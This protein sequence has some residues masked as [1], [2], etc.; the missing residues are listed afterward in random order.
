MCGI[1]GV[2]A[3]ASSRDQLERNAIAMADSLAYRG[4]DDHGIWS[5]AEAGLALTHRRLSIVD[6]SPAGHQPMVSADGRFI[7]TY[8]GEIYNFQDLRPD[9][10]ARGTK[11]RGH[12]DTE[13]MLEAFAVYGVEATVKRLIGMFTIGVWDRRE[14]TLTLVRDR[15]GIKPLYWANFSGLFLF[16]S[17]LK[18]LRAHPGWTP[19][20]NRSAVAA[21]MRH[22]YIPAPHTIYEGVHKLEPGTILTLPWNGEPKIERFWDARAIAHAGLADPLLADDSELTDRLEALLR[23]AVSRRMVADVPVGAFLSGGIDSSTVAALMKAANAGP[24]RTYTIGF[25]LPGFD[26]AVH[27]AAVARHLGTDHTELT[28][29]AKDALNVIPQLPNMYDEPFAD[30]SQIP[31][32][33]VSAMTRRHVT[34]AL[35]G[36]GGDELFAGYNRYQLTTRLWRSFAL[37]P[38][39][40]RRALA[41]MLTAVSADRW[42]QMLSIAPAGMRPPQIGD[43]LHKFAAVLCAEGD[44]DLY[45]RLVTHWDPWRVV[46]GAAE[47]KGVLWDSKIERDFPDLLERMQ[48]LDLVTYLPDDIL[49]KVDR[50]SMAVALE[51]RVPLID[52]RVVEFA[53]R[54]PRAVKIRGGVSKWLLR[55]VLYRHVPK[56]LVERPKM[57][58]G[59][60]LG[61]WLRGP[62]RGWADDLLAESRLRQAGLLDAAR[63]RQIWDAHLNGRRNH[64][65]MLW[66]VLML[67]AWRDRWA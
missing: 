54:L 5:D 8:N 58:F 9:L 33:L 50:A 4:P 64:E 53:W 67:E 27:S 36:D 61:D 60:P 25:E 16:G 42:T 56:A 19:R 39:P 45:R 21:F 29:T 51:A 11:F 57:G 49:T 17:E 40:M 18:A 26:E 46:P 59:I 37:L 55:Q 12:S 24:V 3:S 41:G 22:N 31:T 15:L 62:L 14:R 13:V 38:G 6:L 47:A 32:Y 63:V 30:S 65:Y 20:I 2:I 43:K 34:V 52:H 7:I 66:N 44:T 28:V 35:S 10:E 48:F 23:D 1:A